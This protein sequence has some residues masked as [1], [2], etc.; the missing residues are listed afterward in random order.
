MNSHYS[1][2][3]KPRGC[4]RLRGFCA[5]Q[6]P[7]FSQ[8][9]SKTDRNMDAQYDPDYALLH[10]KVLDAGSRNEDILTETE[11]KQALLIL[12]ES[13]VRLSSLD[14]NEN[15]LIERKRLT[16]HL[17]HVRVA[18]APH[19]RL[20]AEILG[21]IFACAVD[22]DPVE[23]PIRPLQLFWVL[24]QVCSKWRQVALHDPRIWNAVILDGFSI[25]RQQLPDMISIITTLIP[26][27]GPL[28][29]TLRHPT[30][31][32]FVAVVE[33][34]IIPFVHCLTQLN[35][36]IPAH[37]LPDLFA[38]SHHSL[39]NLQS[40]DLYILYH[41]KVV[42]TSF[43][44]KPATSLFFHGAMNLRTLELHSFHSSRMA[45]ALLDLPV[46]WDQLTTLTLIE[47]Q[48]LTPADVHH[49]LR[50]C[51]SLQKL[52]IKFH[53][54]AKI[55]AHVTYNYE[56]HLELPYLREVELQGEINHPPSLRNL[57]LPWSQFTV[58]RIEDLRATAQ[59]HTEIPLK[60]C[61]LLEELTLV[62]NTYL[63]LPD[64]PL[65]LPHLKHLQTN[66]SGVISQLVAPALA[67]LHIT[68]GS[69]RVPEDI[70][71][72][73][74][75][76]SQCLLSEFAYSGQ[77]TRPDSAGFYK[78]LSAVPSITTLDVKSLV[79]ESSILQAITRGEL[80]PQATTVCCWVK[81]QHLEE[82]VAILEV[83]T[84]ESRAKSGARKS[85]IL[86]NVELHAGYT[87]LGCV[88][89]MRTRLDKLNVEFGTS[90][91]VYELSSD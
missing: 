79:L 60:D 20:P 26:R 76:R 30:R 49:V 75:N 44:Q 63:R 81:P 72:D 65:H 21:K 59:Q 5:A 17:S 12:R 18:L 69:L 88:K 1:L 66:E 52:R 57:G 80:L 37:A 13:E 35:L 73:L 8:L 45:G 48:P 53:H 38:L 27:T 19:K 28:S 2:P 86:G 56:D 14:K 22:G 40:L 70:F 34:I 42:D 67:S 71:I 64:G 54:G 31:E 10:Q 62:D 68:G 39:G 47:L 51:F 50:R 7:S 91:S 36:E 84:N 90:W 41:H 32:Y 58:L 15:L 43:T 25:K 74:V 77:V 78:F 46:R 82:F 23:F 33:G 61:V 3:V 24:R 29:L 6:S 89:A 85:G 4:L 87:P 11:R 83:H 9:D 16:L 55:L